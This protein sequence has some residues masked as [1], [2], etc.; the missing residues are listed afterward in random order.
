MLAILRQHRAGLHVEAV[1]PNAATGSFTIYLNRRARR[2]VQ[3]A[4]FV[5]D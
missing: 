5:V 4:W 2:D 3:V 1:V